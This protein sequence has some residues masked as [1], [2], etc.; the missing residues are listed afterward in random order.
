MKIIFPLSAAVIFLISGCS[1]ME[2]DTFHDEVA[3]DGQSPAVYKVP[4][5]IPKPSRS[6][7]PEIDI[8]T[9]S[10][11]T[12]KYNLFALPG[13]EKETE[14]FK[15]EFFQPF[16]KS[17]IP[18]SS[19]WL[20][21]NPDRKK[22]IFVVSQPMKLDPN[23]IYELKMRF[24]GQ[25]GLRLLVTGSEYKNSKHIKSNILLNT[26]SYLNVNGMTSCSKEFAI[27]PGCEEFY[28]SVS[29]MTTSEKG[30]A[31]MLHVEECSIRQ[32]GF[33]KKA[34]PEIRQINL[35]SDYDFSRYPVGEFN[36]IY[37][38][39]GLKAEKWSSIKAEIVNLNG[40]KVLHIV[41]KPENYIYPY[42]ELKKFPV[43]P[44]YH[45]VKLSFKIKGS[46]KIKPGLWWKR[47]S[48]N[49]DYYHGPEVELTNEWQQTTLIHPCMTS[50]V[51]S[52]T[53]SFTSSGNGEFW[54]KDIAVNI[55]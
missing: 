2:P 45:F 7:L 32:T 23:A 40:E 12:E 29:V 24:A 42:M 33:M 4:S 37:K 27:T 3:V 55:E 10:F 11:S 13:L 15:G 48:L 34:A 25:E 52:A 36:K 22:C 30:P 16:S 43:D 9:N 44:K 31:V 46:G 41:R 21:K 38:G 19:G 54:I 18:Y 14:L 51:K 39:Y 28:P 53:M 6:E 17:I 49:W 26:N 47:P 50:D 1:V 5:G 35:A 8:S 20:V